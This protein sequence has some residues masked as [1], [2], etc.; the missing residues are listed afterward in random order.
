MSRLYLQDTYYVPGIVLADEDTLQKEQARLA[1]GAHT[2]AP[3]FPLWTQHICVA[4]VRGWVPF[5]CS[6]QYT[7]DYYCMQFYSLNS[8]RRF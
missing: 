8:L 6:D 2:S 1:F 3:H 4:V 7:Y 5:G